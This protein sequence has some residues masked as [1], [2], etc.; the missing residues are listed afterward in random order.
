MDRPPR[1]PVILL[2]GLL[3]AVAGQLASAG[4]LIDSWIAMAVGFVVALLLSP[5]LLGGIIGMAL[6]ALEGRR[7]RFHGSRR[8]ER[9]TTSRCSA[10]RFCSE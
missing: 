3:L 5:F 8:P 4:G 7:R 6:E 9:H 2:G 1:E 10:H